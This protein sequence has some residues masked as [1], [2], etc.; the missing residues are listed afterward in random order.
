M[1]AYLCRQMI[2][3]QVQMY[4]TVIHTSYFTEIYGKQRMDG[5]IRPV[6]I[7]VP[8]TLMVDPA[9][10]KDRHQNE[11]IRKEFKVKCSNSSTF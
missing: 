6:N 5:H 11:S 4:E 1:S 9:C 10:E 3:M 7:Q 8:F 2:L